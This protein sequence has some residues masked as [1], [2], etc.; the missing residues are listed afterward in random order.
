MRTLE[1][2]DICGYL[3]Y[4]LKMSGKDNSI[5]PIENNL[6]INSLM[7][8]I[9]MYKHLTPILHPLS[10]LYRV[11]T[12]NGKDI[13]PIVECAKIAMPNQNWD[14]KLWNNGIVIERC[15]ETGII[16][17]KFDYCK[18]EMYFKQTG[19]GAVK[20]IPQLFDFLDELKIDY[21]GLIDAGLAIDAN[22]LEIQV[23][24]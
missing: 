15:E 24:K 13:I 3:P 1:L 2:K 19:D 23:Y 16:I 6:Y 8:K 10:D 12:H 22:T 4:G 21:R 20:N 17:K 7:S 11:I 5:F 9:F 14:E 18:N